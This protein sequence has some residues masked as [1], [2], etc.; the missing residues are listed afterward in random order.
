MLDRYSI[1]RLVD[2]IDAL[3]R[4]LLAD[5]R[6][7]AAGARSPTPARAA[8]ARRRRAA[9]IAPAT[10]RLRVML[11]SQYFPPEIG[12]TQIAD[13]VVRRVPRR[14]RVTR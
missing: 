11:V 7:R 10:A 3:Y 13:A 8:D 14:P 1:P 5:G 2:D 6:R 4:A 9:A 12:A